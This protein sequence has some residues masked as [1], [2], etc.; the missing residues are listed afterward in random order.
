MAKRIFSYFIIFLV[1]ICIF[2]FQIY[3]I[4]SRELFGVKPNL[5]LIS[6]IV[7]SLWYGLYTGTIYSFFIGITTD[8]MFGNSFGI[9]TLSYIIVGLVIGYLNYNYRRENKVSL[10]YLT[11]FGT[12]IFE[13][14]QFVIYLF[15]NSGS[16]N[17]FHLIIQIIISS[18]LNVIL[19]FILYSTFSKISE[20]AES[21]NSYY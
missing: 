12:C 5:I 14:T 10:L 19:A 6:V 2:L 9:F 4:D 11:I 8:I 21:T 15:L 3:V 18:I 13:F 16:S 1:L 17:I 7:M 20:Y